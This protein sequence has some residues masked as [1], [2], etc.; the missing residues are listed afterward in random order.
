MNRDIPERYAG[1][2]YFKIGEVAKIAGVKPF[3]LRFW[4]SEFP[5][6]KPGR[7]ATGQRVYR[8]NDVL[9]VLAIRELLY[10]KKFTIPGAKAH[11]AA[12]RKSREP[13]PEP[14]VSRD[15]I[16]AELSAIARMLSD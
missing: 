12:L 16:V 8:R 2:A 7:T 10:E 5:E 6:I 15:E 13:V 4:E 11:F 9:T 14:A 1:K 3:V